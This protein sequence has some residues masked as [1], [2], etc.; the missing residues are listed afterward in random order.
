MKTLSRRVANRHVA[1]PPTK[2]PIINFVCYIHPT[3]PVLLRRTGWEIQDDVHDDY[4]DSVSRDNGKTWSPPQIVGR[5]QA[6][7]GGHILTQEGGAVYLSDRDEI[8]AVTYETL[9]P[10]GHD[11][12]AVAHTVLRPRITQ[13]RPADLNTAAPFSSD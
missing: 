7:Q 9:Q 8:V 12:F 13:C 4:A 11:G 1:G 6:V 5:R 2:A 10:S 3:E